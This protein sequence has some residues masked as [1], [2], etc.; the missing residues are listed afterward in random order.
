M[1]AQ[2]VFSCL[3][4][5]HIHHIAVFTRLN[6][7][8]RLHRNVEALGSLCL[9]HQHLKFLAA[10]ISHSEIQSYL[11]CTGFCHYERWSNEI[12]IFHKV[13]LCGKLHAVAVAI[14][15][16]LIFPFCGL[17]AACAL[18]LGEQSVHFVGARQVSR[19]RQ[20]LWSHRTHI[21]CGHTCS[22]ALGSAEHSFHLV[23]VETGFQAISFSVLP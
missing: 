7:G 13:S 10:I 23:G 16:R 21:F 9:A 6:R 4:Q 19:V 17:C 22:C 3:W 12:F 2:I 18:K 8:Q 11:I 15:A 14:V 20:C 1:Q 5:L